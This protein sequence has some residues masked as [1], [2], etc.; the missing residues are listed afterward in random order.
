MG[1]PGFAL[2][3]RSRLAGEGA[4]KHCAILAP[5]F[6]GKPAP[7]KSAEFR[8]RTISCR[9]RLAGE[10]VVKHRVNLEG[11][12]VGKPVHL[13]AAPCVRCLIVH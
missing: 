7:T 2:S 9:S 4:L 3:C 5:P 11:P 10:G 1:L 8:D 13:I 6:A 12:F